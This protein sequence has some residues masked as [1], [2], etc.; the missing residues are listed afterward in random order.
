MN[1]LNEYF[2][3]NYEVK[4]FTHIPLP[5]KPEQLLT[6]TINGKRFYVL[7]DGQKYPSI[8]SVLSDRNNAG[9]T[10]WRESVGEQVANTIMRNAAK[11][12]TAVHTLTEDYLNNKEL[13]KQDVLPTALFTILKPELDKINNIV[14]QEESLYS[15]KWGVA[16]R[17]DCIAEFQGKLS[18]IDFKTST[19]DKKEEWVE[20]Y[21]IQTAAYCEM[22]EEMYGQPIDQIVILIVTEEGAT[23][24]FIKNKNDYL[25][26]LKPAIEEF[27]R[28]FKEK[29]NEKNN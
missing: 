19:K 26:L 20:N 1:K 13:S 29:E 2:K 27:N 28:K 24:T 6:K 22:Y 25:P 11:R 4:D 9:I 18:V 15:N 3:K 16:G 17:V 23:Q 8:T 10:K 12:G 7:P 5:T 21:F 14:M